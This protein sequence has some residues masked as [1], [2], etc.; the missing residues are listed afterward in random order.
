MYQIKLIF[1]SLDTNKDNSIN[2]FELNKVFNQVDME[3]DSPFN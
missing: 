1:D 3:K 2:Y